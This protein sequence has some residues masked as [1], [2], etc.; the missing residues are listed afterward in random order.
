MED[1]H[2]SAAGGQDG[3]DGPTPLDKEMLSLKSESEHDQEGLPPGS[4]D[5]SQPRS[6]N[7][8]QLAS[9]ASGPSGVGDFTA[10]AQRW[11][12]VRKPAARDS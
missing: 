2:S 6:A 9:R 8:D 3:Q 5:P 1:F 12:A 10:Y 4:S 11:T 7:L